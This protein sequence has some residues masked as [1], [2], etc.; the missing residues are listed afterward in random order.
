[1]ALFRECNMQ[2]WNGVLVLH[3][4]SALFTSYY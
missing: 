2:R 4:L 1:M 3:C